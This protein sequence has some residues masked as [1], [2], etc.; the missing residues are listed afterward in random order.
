PGP[1][2]SLGGTDSPPARAPGDQAGRASSRQSSRRGGSLLRLRSG[3]VLLLCVGEGLAQLG[4]EDLQAVGIVLH[5]DRVLVGLV[6]LLL[7]RGRLLRRLAERRRRHEEEYHQGQHEKAHGSSPYRH[8]RPAPVCVAMVPTVPPPV[9][10]TANTPA[11][12]SV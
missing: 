5:G 9:E 2:P 6:E 8:R 11:L 10:Q 4:D 1:S 7:A 12:Q 3:L